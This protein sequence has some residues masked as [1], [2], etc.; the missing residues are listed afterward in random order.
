MVTQQL[1]FEEKC[2]LDVHLRLLKDVEGARYL[3]PDDNCT[4]EVDKL[5]EMAEEYKS[6]QYWL[7]YRDHN[8]AVVKTAKRSY[9][10]HFQ[11][12]ENE[13]KKMGRT[14][15]EFKMRIE[16][17]PSIELRD[18]L[19]NDLLITLFESRPKLA[20]E[21]H[22]EGEEPKPELAVLNKETGLPVLETLNRGVTKV[23]FDHWLKKS[24]A[25]PKYTS[26]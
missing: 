6:S 12:V 15:F 21:P 2:T 10:R 24:P 4:I 14:D 25:D 3:I 26:S 16:E 17:A 7:E 19:Q 22:E 13:D 11:V 8:G 18:W 23:K 1:R 9:I 5:D 20:R